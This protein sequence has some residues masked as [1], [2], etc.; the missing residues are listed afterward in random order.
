MSRVE[1]QKIVAKYAQKLRDEK[2]PFFAVYL[3]G[4]YVKGNPKEESDIDVAVLSD[5]LKKDWNKNEEL[6]WKWSVAVDPRIEPIGLTPRDFNDD[7]DPMVL[8]IKKSR[9]RIK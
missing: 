7:A 3:F 9:I 8:E 4:S 5:K 1:A 2:F 6:L